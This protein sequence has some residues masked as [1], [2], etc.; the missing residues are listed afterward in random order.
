M[1]YVTEVDEDTNKTKSMQKVAE[2][3]TLI[4]LVGKT[5]RDRVRNT[6]TR[7]HCEI[8]NTVRWSRQCRRQWY[9][10]VRRMD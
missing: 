9:D 5:K 2:M 1:T 8:Q 7:E 3:K 10:H 4:T 6:D